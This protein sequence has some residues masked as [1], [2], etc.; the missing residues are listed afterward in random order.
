MKPSESGAAMTA[1]PKKE[2]RQS[3]RRNKRIKPSASG[4]AQ[5]LN[6]LF[7]CRYGAVMK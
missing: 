5:K 6:R 7:L 1:D 3:P 2:K 4:N